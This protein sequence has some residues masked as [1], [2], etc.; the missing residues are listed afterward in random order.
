MTRSTPRT[1]QPSTTTSKRRIALR[2]IVLALDGSGVTSSPRRAGANLSISSVC[3]LDDR[4]ARESIVTRVRAAHASAPCSRATPA[5]HHA[6]SARPFDLAQLDV[7]R[8]EGGAQSEL[9]RP[10][11]P[12]AAPPPDTSSM[13]CQVRS[14][15]SV[16][17]PLAS[18]KSGCSMSHR[19]NGSVVWMPPTSQLVEGAAAVGRSPRGRSSATDEQLGH[20]WVVVLADDAP[21]LHAGVDADARSGRLVA[22]ASRVPAPARNRS[23]GCSAR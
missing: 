23:A 16:D 7:R 1:R 11:R 20:Q 4:A 3:R 9:G 18:A 8:V 21:L 6:S 22:S 17:R 12:R 19:W 2:A 15:R 13:G 14:T 10:A 5:C